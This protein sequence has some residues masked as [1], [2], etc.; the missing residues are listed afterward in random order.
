MESFVVQIRERFITQCPRKNQ[1]SSVLLESVGFIIQDKID[2][3]I[4]LSLKDVY[5][6]QGYML[7]LRVID[8]II[9]QQ[10]NFIVLQ[11][12]PLTSPDEF[13]FLVARVKYWNYL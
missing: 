10:E 11:F 5:L 4:L 8:I 13:T 7:V 1:W 2:G 9:L 12:W 3:V 6:T